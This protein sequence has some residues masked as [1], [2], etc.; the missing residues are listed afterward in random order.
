MIKKED[1]PVRIKRKTI[2]NGEIIITELAE[3]N[4]SLNEIISLLKAQQ[5]KKINDNDE[6]EKVKRW[7]ETTDIKLV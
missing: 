6:K 1:R 5:I 7:L 2:R 4:K 3:I